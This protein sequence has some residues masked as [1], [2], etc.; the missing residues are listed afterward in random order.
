MQVPSNSRP[1]LLLLALTAYPKGRVGKVYH[2]AC[3]MIDRSPILREHF[4][5]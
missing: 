4:H 3:K 2:A 5:A 1:S